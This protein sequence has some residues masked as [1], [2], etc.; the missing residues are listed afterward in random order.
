MAEVVAEI[1]QR[2]RAKYP[3]AAIT[4]EGGD[5]EGGLPVWRV[6]RDGHASKG[7]PIS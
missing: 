1:Q 7:Y 4:V 3:V 6:H 2:L 5:G